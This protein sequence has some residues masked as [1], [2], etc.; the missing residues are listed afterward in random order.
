MIKS[1][2]RRVLSR[3]FGFTAAACALLLNPGEIPAQGVSPGL[4]NIT[5]RSS[6]GQFIALAK[7]YLRSSRVVL[8]LAQEPQ[9][10][11]L[12]PN[13][14]AISAERIRQAIWHEMDF[15]GNWESRIYLRLRPADTADDVPVVSSE[16]FRSSWQ[17]AVD[18]PEV[19][20]KWRYVR[21]I[22][23]VVLIEYAN[24]G[25]TPRSSEVPVWLIEGITAYLMLSGEHEFVLSRPE[26]SRDGKSVAASIVQARREHP[27][28]IAQNA[29]SRR[30]ATSFHDLCWTSSGP[31]TAADLEHYRLSA[32]VFFSEL[33]RLPK[34]RELVR[35][36]LAELPK[37][38]NWQIAFLHGFRDH[39][40]RLL[41][42]EKW[43]AL[44]AAHYEGKESGE[45]WP[46]AESLRQLEESLIV[47]V[48]VFSDTNSLPTNSRVPL[49]TVIREWKGREQNSVLEQKLVE[50]EML[51]IRMAP[52]IAPTVDGYRQALRYFLVEKGRIRA[53]RPHLEEAEYRKIVIDTVRQLQRLDEMRRSLKAPSAN[54]VSAVPAA[55]NWSGAAG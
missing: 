11:R 20:E 26:Y 9:F 22:T 48:E 40:P 52:E 38:H 24:R 25:G 4:Q 7:P 29:L 19:V 13:V 5:A 21:A 51:R 44:Q 8:G 27:L 14:L 32:M 30:P 18:L 34:G 12:D 37:Y 6:S 39:F 28:K 43:W 31:Q 2:R 49:Q 16:R 47:V 50:L 17:Y 10:V 1:H 55:G 3:G 53:P 15:A 35:A 33:L 45:V 41:D 23:Q 54:G 36:F 42:V 46:V